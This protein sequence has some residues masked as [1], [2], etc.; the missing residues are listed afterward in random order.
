[1]DGSEV[2]KKGMRLA[3]RLYLFQLFHVAFGAVPSSDVVAVL[4]GTEAQEAFAYLSRTD[5]AVKTLLNEISSD[6]PAEHAASEVLRFSMA[7][8]AQ[9]FG[10]S[11]GYD[12]VESLK[13]SY[14]RLFIVP[15]D[16][17]ACLWESLYQ[18]KEEML[19]QPSTIEVRKLY[20]RFGYQAKDYL[21]FPED[22]LSMMLDFLGNLAVRAFE[23]F[24]NSEDEKVAELL[25]A[26]D[27]LTGEHILKWLPRLCEQLACKDGIGFYA[28]YAE[29]LRAFLETDRRLV[30]GWG[31]NG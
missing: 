4:V 28:R 20:E 18:G 23:A 7:F 2:R 13:S 16:S 22:H 17:F 25:G 24:S 3:N 30:S 5:D 11:D 10:E 14:N 19:F 8:A 21:R 31:K 1:M 26:S 27:S 15:G 29:A 6:A 9:R 12:F